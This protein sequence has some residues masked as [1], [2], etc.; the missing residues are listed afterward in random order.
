MTG[1]IVAF[2]N[3]ARSL[4]NVHS[5]QVIILSILREKLRVL[6]IIVLYINLMI[7]LSATELEVKCVRL[8]E[9]CQLGYNPQCLAYSFSYG[10]SKSITRS[11]KEGLRWPAKATELLPFG[12]GYS[13]NELVFL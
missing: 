2:I 13:C 6:Y 4:K 3:F 7:F 5:L 12:T 1:L 8:R 9:K 11:S 10:R